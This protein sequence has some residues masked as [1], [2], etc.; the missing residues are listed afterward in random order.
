MISV[1]RLLQIARNTGNEALVSSVSEYDSVGCRS[2]G[3]THVLVRMFA[4]AM[5]GWMDLFSL[6]SFGWTA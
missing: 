6:Y 3:H 5:D 1:G 4:I 2:S